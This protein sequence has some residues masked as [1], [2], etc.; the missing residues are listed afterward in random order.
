MLKDSQTGDQLPK[1]DVSKEKEPKS[2][3]GIEKKPK[4]AAKV[5]PFPTDDRVNPYATMTFENINYK[6]AVLNKTY[7]GHMMSI[8]CLAI[9]PKKSIVAKGSEFTWKIWTVP[10]GELILSGEGHKDWISGLSFHPKGSNLATASGDC[11]V[12]IWD[13]ID[14]SCTYTFKDDIQPIWSVAYHD[15]GDFLVTGSMD[16]TAKLIDAN[17]MKTRYTFRGHVDSV[18]HVCSIF[19]YFHYVLRR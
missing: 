10:Q 18:N 3:G 8:S 11:K 14:A 19:K 12:K 1:L 7:K 17:I 6:N 16:H 9:H 2:P 15:T 4:K 5:T 13:C